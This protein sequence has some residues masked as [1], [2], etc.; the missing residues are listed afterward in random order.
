MQPTSSVFLFTTVSFA[1]NFL[2]SCSIVPFQNCNH[3]LRLLREEG[4][5][6]GD[7]SAMALT[8]QC[9]CKVDLSYSKLS[10]FTA[11]STLEDFDGAHLI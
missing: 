8:L 4:L 9:Q 2:Q 6:Y 1:L 10:A 3:A 5:I 11:S 7:L